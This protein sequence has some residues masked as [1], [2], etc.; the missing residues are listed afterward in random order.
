VIADGDDALGSR[1]PARAD[2]VVS[3]FPGSGLSMRIEGP[4]L[5][6]LDAGL[7]VAALRRVVTEVVCSRWAQRSL[8]AGLQAVPREPR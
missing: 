1:G 6:E 8:P 2:V 4:D 7:S 5:V 3:L